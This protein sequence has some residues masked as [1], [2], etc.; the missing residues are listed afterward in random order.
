MLESVLYLPQSFCD[1][2]LM[3]SNKNGYLKEIKNQC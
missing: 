1:L 3:F 2:T